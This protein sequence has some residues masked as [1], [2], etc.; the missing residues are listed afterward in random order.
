MLVLIGIG[1]L[2]GVVT[3]VSPCVLPV[4]PVL[5]AGG[6]SGRKPVRI[7]AGLVASFSVFTLFAAWILDQLGLPQDFLRNLAIVLLFV[8]AA[9]L[10]VPQAAQLIER[11]LAVFSRFR[12][13]GVGGG[14]FLGAT[15]GL[16]FVPCAGPVLATVTVVAAENTVGVRAIVLTIA[17]AV[18]AAIPMLLIARGGREASAHLRRRA[19]SLRIGSGVLIAAV[20]LGLTFHLDDRI[21]QFTP[22]YTT[23][24]QK[25][26]EANSA[27]KKALGK[28]RGGGA[29]LAAVHKTTGGLPDFGVAPALHAD[30]AWLN[31]APLDLQQLRGKVVLVDFWTYSCINCLRTLPHLKAWYAAYHDKGLVIVGVHTPEFAFEHVTSNVRGAV[32]RLGVT[33]P[34]VQDNRYK[35]WDN[36]ANQYWPAE[37]LIDRSGH[38]RHT[39]FGEGEYD[40]TEALIRTLLGA[41]GRTA[42]HVADA[43]PTGLMTPETYLGYARLD[44]Y[45]GSKL[46]PDVTAPYTFAKS[47]PQNE[48]SYSGDWRVETDRIVA[49]PSAR[50]RL[51][52]EAANVYIVLGGHGTVHALIDGKPTSPIAVDTQRL[53]TVRASKR[54]IGGLLELRLSRGIQAY[55]FT[56]G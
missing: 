54:S 37:Y 27:A 48:L 43:T 44:R 40:K 2:A 32:K 10:L 11:P 53:Y 30:G 17:Y 16:V 13:R 31:S 9:T 46:V 34:V 18:G 25:K 35:T 38:V 5:L 49:G 33:W 26:I 55:S 12:P 19:N 47:I 56:F 41:R 45:V 14:F 20:A 23:F 8:M 3:A 22:G 1:L 42:R 50:L 28:V 52:F 39:H 4:L 6:A 21:A 7:V 29:A 36:Y 15:L 24:L 51:N